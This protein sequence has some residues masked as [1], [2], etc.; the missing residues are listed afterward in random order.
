MPSCAWCTPQPFG[1]R[2]TVQIAPNAKKTAVVGVV[3]DAIKI[4]LQAQPVDGQAN[5]AL[6]KWL[7]K[8]LEVARGAVVISHG[9]TSRRKLVDVSGVDADAV[10]GLLLPD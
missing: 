2:L 7:A 5:A 6:V 1:V 3:D 4:R 10:A 8:Q 9:T